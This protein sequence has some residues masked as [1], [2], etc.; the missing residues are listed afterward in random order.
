MTAR[1]TSWIAGTGVLLFLVATYH[2]GAD[3]YVRID[4]NLDEWV[5][6]YVALAAD[7]SSPFDLDAIVD[8]VLGGIPRN[9]L[10]SSVQIGVTLYRFLD[11][12]TAYIL[13]EAV[14]RAVALLGMLLLLRRH[15]LR[16][17]D[18]LAVL[19]ASLS[20]ALLPFFPPGFLSIAGLPLLLSAVLDFRKRQASAFHWLIIAVFPF[21]SSMI[22]VGVFL[23]AGIGTLIA[24]D[25]RREKRLNVPLTSALFTLGTLY[26][27]SE[28]RL[29]YQTFFDTDYVSHREV[30]MRRTLPLGKIIETAARHF[31]FSSHRHIRSVQW[32]AMALAIAFGATG[33]RALAGSGARQVD[34]ARGRRPLLLLTGLCLACAV[35]EALWLS[36]LVQG[37]LLQTGLP[38][39]RSFN[40]SRLFWAQPLLFALA[41]AFALD[42][43][44]RA[45]LRGR[46]LAILLIG[47]QIAALTIESDG[48]FER[49]K[50]GMTWREYYAPK[51]FAEIQES[52]G[53][54]AS[55]YRV[56][57]LGLVPAI[58]LFNGFRVVDGFHDNY[59]LSYKHAFRRAIAG[60]LEKSN[61]LERFFDGWG[62]RAYLFSSELG[63]VG[64]YRKGGL[65]TRKIGL[66]S[67]RDLA[68]DTRALAELGCDYLLSAVSI[69]NADSLGLS[70]KGRFARPE[71]PWLIH[72][73]ALP[74]LSGGLL[75]ES[76]SDPDT[77]RATAQLDPQL[78]QRR[79]R[80]LL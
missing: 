51:L 53:R 46:Q 76:A 34:T 67:I 19:G 70:H 29:L 15:L 52:I 26:L 49:R 77:L 65:Y 44:A 16:G 35:V 79:T 28:Y 71:S 25:A 12:L 68:L 4:D 59:P 48:A 40:W 13:N 32:P 17:G 57:S 1:S 14:A 80:P 64:G 2:S 62:S 10:T 45:G 38:I 56:A 50:T 5:P 23:C 33:V 24:L 78:G 7:A 69:E 3:S 54:P 74:E 61:D 27:I 41:F 20:F 55:E 63:R 47:M 11:P 22:L 73:Y 21:Y 60:E 58:A 6:I 9:S 37:A 72:L 30:F 39:L 43:I 75:R 36:S 66:F 42:R 18:E 8:P 31:F